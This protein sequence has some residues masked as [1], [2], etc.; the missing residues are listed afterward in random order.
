MCTFKLSSIPNILEV[1]FSVNY[2]GENLHPYM[3]RG[4]LS[5]STPNA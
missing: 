5:F 2:L 1:E 3:Q 4:C